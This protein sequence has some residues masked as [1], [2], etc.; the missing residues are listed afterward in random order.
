MS[1]KLERENKQLRQALMQAI[2]A[3]KGVVPD[4]AYDFYKEEQYRRKNKQLDIDVEWTV[5][6]DPNNFN[7]PVGIYNAGIF[8]DFYDNQNEFL[9]ALF[10]RLLKEV[11]E[12]GN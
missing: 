11:E 3:P 5:E 2:E 7:V 12:N 9:M 6:Y 1:H 8:Y 10:S 4:S